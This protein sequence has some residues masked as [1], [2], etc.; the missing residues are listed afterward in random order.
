MASRV[1]ICVYNWRFLGSGTNP[2]FSG[3]PRFEK[4]PSR[5][6]ETIVITRRTQIY[7]LPQVREIIAQHAINLTAFS[8]NTCVRANVRVATHH[9]RPLSSMLLITEPI[10]NVSR[11]GGSVKIA[12][13]FLTARRVLTTI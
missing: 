7:S 13:D 2:I 11:V 10:V 3:Q 1:A 5:V 4:A 9:L 12:I 8:I 6:F